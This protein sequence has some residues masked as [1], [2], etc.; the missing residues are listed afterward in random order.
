VVGKRTLNAPTQHHSKPSEHAIEQR[1]CS[2]KSSQKDVKL[3]TIADG[4]KT[5][6]SISID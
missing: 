4:V 2:V 3:N 5:V 6:S 1:R